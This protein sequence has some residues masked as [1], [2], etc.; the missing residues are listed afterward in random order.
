MNLTV[1]SFGKL[2][3]PGLRQA[4]DTYIRNLKPW[5]KLEEI[6]WKPQKV[7]SS[8]EVIRKKIQQKEG[9]K[10]LELIHRKNRHQKKVILLDETGTS[11]STQN[12]AHTI[13]SFQQNQT[14][15]VI[16]LIGSSLGFSGEVKKE[17]DLKICFGKQTIAHELTKVVLLEQIYRT[18]S[19]LNHH[20]YHNEG[21]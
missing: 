7:P 9:E 20:P 16:F 11:L 13:E 12:W 14:Q 18:Y 3:T 10:I 1:V 5:V 2:K 4:A 8:S 17:A 19:I 21:E 15:E 6:E